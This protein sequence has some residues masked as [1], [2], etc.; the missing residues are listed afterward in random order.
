MGYYLIQVTY[1]IFSMVIKDGQKICSWQAAQLWIAPSS[2]KYFSATFLQ[3]L[4]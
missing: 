2:D 1:L 4:L 3:H